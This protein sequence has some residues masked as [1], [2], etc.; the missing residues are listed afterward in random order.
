MAN[1]TLNYTVGD[2]DYFMV[3][4]GEDPT[5][6]YVLKFTSWSNSS[7]S[8]KFD[9]SIVGDSGNPCKFVDDTHGEIDLGH[10]VIPV[11]FIGASGTSGANL[12]VQTYDTTNDAGIAT[13]IFTVEDAKIEFRAKD[14]V[15]FNPAHNLT[16]TFGAG[17]VNIVSNQWRVNATS[18][19][20]DV[21]NTDYTSD[22]GE[23]INVTLAYD[24]TET[25]ADVSA[26]ALGGSSTTTLVSDS[27][28]DEQYGMTDYGTWVIRETDD[29][30][31]AK[32]LVPHQEVNMRVAIAGV[33]TSL[34]GTGT[35]GT[36]SG[37]VVVPSTASKFADEIA[38]IENQNLLVVGGPCANS[39]AATL[40]GNPANCAE[41]FEPGKGIIKLFEHSNGNAALLVAGYSGADTRLASLVVADRT[42]LTRQATGVDEI[43]VQGTSLSQVTISYPTMDTAA[44]DTAA[45][46][47]AADDTTT[48]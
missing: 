4:V 33:D 3:N 37:Q 8:E 38:D 6:T 40:M 46:D 22:A 15:G 43:I 26:V 1:T 32:V 2:N 23:I 45:D 24:T 5:Y 17:P 21:E 30:Q 29:N 10:T 39:V 20:Q 31:W 28:K 12:S 18:I 47:A 16:Q 11:N 34:T 42:Q 35:S 27:D 14:S 13:A 7:S 19:T 36:A 25:E 44:D 48:A 9:C 41:G